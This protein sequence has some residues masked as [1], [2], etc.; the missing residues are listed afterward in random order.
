MIGKALGQYRIVEKLGSGGMGVVYKA[1]DTML[2]RSV[3]LKFLPAE[4]LNSAAAIERFLREARAAAA[5]NHPNICTIHEVGAYEGQ[6]FYSMELLEGQTLQQRIAQSLLSTEELL[7]EAIQIASALEAAHAKGIIHRDIKPANVFITQSG[8]VKLLDFGLAKL[9]GERRQPADSAAS[10]EGPVTS[11]GSALGTVAY[12]SPE[13]AR[14]EDLDVRTDLFSFGVVLYE[15]ATGQ[16]AFGGSTSAV[17]F[18]AILT[19]AP[20]SLNRWNPEVSNDLE[21][22]INKALEK[23]RKLRYQSATEMYADLQRLKRDTQARQTNGTVQNAEPKSKLSGLKRWAVIVC[24]T[25]VLGAVIVGFNIAG[26][27]DILLTIGGIRDA[28]QAT[29]IE[30]IAVLPMTNLSG[31]PQ[32]DYF[33]DGMTEALITDLSKIRAL[34]VISRTSVMQ[35]KGVTKKP[36]P[37]IARELGV[38]G[39]VEGSVLRVGDRVRITAQLIEA[40]SDRHLWAENYDRD[41]RDILE[42]QSSLAQAIAREISIVITPQEQSLLASIHPINPQAYEL[43][44]KGISAKSTAESADYYRRAVGIDPFY[45]LAWTQLAWSYNNSGSGVALSYAEAY[46]KAKM[47]AQKALDID[48]DQ[49]DAHA[50]LAFAAMESDWDWSLAER[51][52]LRALEL[53][54]N[55]VLAHE[56]YANYL[57]RMGR[58]PKALAEAQHGVEL[59]PLWPD[60]YGLQAFTCW[61]AREY[62]QAFKAAQ[63]SLTLRGLQSSTADSIIARVYRDRGMYAE[64]IAEWERM[65]EDP[66]VLGHGGNAYARAGK[67]TKAEECI[68]KLKDW[69]ARDRLGSY[70]IALVYAGLGDKDRAFEWLV[71]ALEVRDKGM[72]FL[73]VDPT[74]DSLRPDPRFHALLR[75]MNFPEK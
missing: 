67:K 15:M 14:G 69:V 16:Q 31:D 19:K 10:T 51:E 71:K 49:A 1:E 20:I 28:V 6:H 54:A 62:D 74:L 2:G 63:R 47:A 26:L 41:L 5:L 17:I 58:A 36:L 65:K 22:I 43:Y 7:D 66:I 68:S 40:A 59:N 72:T 11:P 70:E 39:V 55:S 75:R 21:R 30:S 53:N 52:C 9:A 50:A 34:K 38:E 35:Y 13:Q 57:V 8:Q 61:L 73:K 60:A 25:I 48:P 56:T 18:N 32:Q 23:D 44:L 64:S 24:I 46:H 3:A 37:Q 4:L 29:K 33:A 27:R 45:A 42:L 12:M